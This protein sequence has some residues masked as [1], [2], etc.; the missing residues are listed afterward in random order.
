M[1]FAQSPTPPTLADT[2]ANFSFFI[3]GNPAEWPHSLGIFI[4]SKKYS[5]CAVLI[6]KILKIKL[7]LK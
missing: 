6:V 1:D 2:L 7:D 3:S 4:A 5:W